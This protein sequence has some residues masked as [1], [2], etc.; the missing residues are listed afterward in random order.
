M[1]AGD[2]G[3]KSVLFRL[4]QTVEETSGISECLLA[5]GPVPV[6]VPCC[7]DPVAQECPQDLVAQECPQDPVVQECRQ[8]PSEFLPVVHLEDLQG[9]GLQEGLPGVRLLPLPSR[10]A[11]YDD[12]SSTSFIYNQSITRYS[13]VLKSYKNGI[14]GVTCFILYYNVQ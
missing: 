8:A 13:T 9:K 12:L 6:P 3:I 14:I 2:S 4:F 11:T 1:E 10:Y 5:Q 7:Q